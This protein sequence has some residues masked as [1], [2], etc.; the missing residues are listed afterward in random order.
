MTARLRG[1]L[2]SGDRPY[3]FGPLSPNVYV[4]GAG[5]SVTCWEEMTPPPHESPTPMDQLG[6]VFTQQHKAK[7]FLE[8]D[9]QGGKKLFESMAICTDKGEPYCY[10][11]IRTWS[12]YTTWRK[13]SSVRLICPIHTMEITLN[14]VSIPYRTHWRSRQKKQWVVVVVALL[15]Y[16]HGKNLRSCRDGQLT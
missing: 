9:G 12:T 13:M 3:H 16:V 15:F 7:V 1:A 5:K 2:L 6:M 4:M 14:G 8:V 10:H 11:G